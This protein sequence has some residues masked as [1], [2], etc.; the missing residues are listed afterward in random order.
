M[1][2]QISE[3]EVGEDIQGYYLVKMSAIKQTAAGKKYLD[4]TLMDATGE[5][6]AKVWE[7]EDVLLTIFKEGDIVKISAKCNSWQSQKQLSVNKYRPINPSDNIRIESFVPTAPIPAEIL[8]DNIIAAIDGMHHAEIQKIV[9]AIVLERQEKLLFYPAAKSNH[10][11]VRS[12]LMYHI[13]RMLELGKAMAGVYASVNLDLLYAGI[14]LHDICKI[15]EMATNQLGLVSEYTKQGN[16]LGHITLGIQLIGE[17]GKQLHISTEIVE[18]LQHMLLTHHYEPEFGSPK[19]PM[20]LEAEL[21]HYIDM[22]DARVYD[23][24]KAMQDTKPGE[25]S[26]AIWSMDKR[27]MYNHGLEVK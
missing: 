10:H 11:A 21:L 20:F 9:K 26:E 6:N 4:T 14:I 3:F 27:R 5:I 22:I 23:I 1:F 8:Y 18:L 15:D 2:K 12:G 25:F 19:K 7:G 13:Y 24:S 16:L 17:K